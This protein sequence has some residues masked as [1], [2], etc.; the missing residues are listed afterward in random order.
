MQII[1]FTVLAFCTTLL[2][3]CS[4]SFDSFA[5]KQLMHVAKPSAGILPPVINPITPTN[6]ILRDLPPPRQRVAVAVYNYADQ[7]GQR[8]AL[9]NGSTLSTAVTQGS[10]SM[11][12]KALQDAGEG[13]WFMVVEREKLNNL[14]KERSIIANMRKVYLGEKG[15]NP[16]ALP[17]LLF[18]GILLEGGVI[19][20]DTN[21]ISGGIGARYLGIGGDVK[22]RQDTVTVALRAISTK[23]GQVLAT[24]ETSKTIV[25][26]GI[27]GSIFKFVA[28]D[29][30]AEGEAGFSKNEPDQIAVQ[31]AIEKA[32]LSL[33]IEGTERGLWKFSNKRKEDQMQKE[34]Y[35]EQF[36][37]DEAQEKLLQSRARQWEEARRKKIK[38]ERA[39][40]V[41]KK[42][43]DAAKALQKNGPQQGQQQGQ[44]N[45]QN[46][47]IQ[48]GAIQNGD[49]R[50]RA[51]Q[52][53][54][55][56]T[57][58][59]KLRVPARI[60]A[61][62][63]QQRSRPVQNTVRSPQQTRQ[64]QNRIQNTQSGVK[65]VVV[66]TGSTADTGR[67]VALAIA[68]KGGGKPGVAKLSADRLD[69]DKVKI[70][71]KSTSEIANWELDKSELEVQGGQG[72][73]TTDL[74]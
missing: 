44:N 21:T 13:A 65:G 29:R 34:Y 50:G 14:L 22:Y 37:S 7:T 23:T 25:G 74:R 52:E 9:D 69:M 35:T 68:G 42:A 58:G 32:V 30:L 67:I 57:G 66:Q 41:R 46:R 19:G 20:Y 62:Q 5:R 61:G 51:G 4:K 59:L 31:Q 36:G 55:Y 45:G 3:G 60:G 33:I 38:A 49:V 40:I 28:L 63:G 12:I 2:M 53:V 54:P 47:T 71:T 1:I 39:R 6:K 72:V 64:S 11:L 70:V 24:V 27:R 48:K 15:I 17:P 73:V 26:Y 56:K 16:K 18:A 10:T 43:A 8:K